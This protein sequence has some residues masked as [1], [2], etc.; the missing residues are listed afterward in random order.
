MKI[1]FF[2]FKE[3]IG[4]L[5]FLS[6]LNAVFITRAKIKKNAAVAFGFREIFSKEPV[7]KI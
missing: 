4:E 6:S 2:T 1:N 7:F 5:H 3:M